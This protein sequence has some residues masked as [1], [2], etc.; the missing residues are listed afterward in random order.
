MKTDGLRTGPTQTPYFAALGPKTVVAHL[1]AFEFKPSAFFAIVT[2][3]TVDGKVTLAAVHVHIFGHQWDR[4]LGCQ[5]GKLAIPIPKTERH[6]DVIDH[7]EPKQQFAFVLCD[8]H[9]G[10]TV[11][12]V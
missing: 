5:M 12:R 7:C 11:S 3:T 6:E 4:R 8:K 1:F 2:S 10:N 9:H